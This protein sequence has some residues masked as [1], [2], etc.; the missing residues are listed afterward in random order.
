M[1][2]T[3][4]I[5]YVGRQAVKVLGQLRKASG[6]SGLGRVGGIRKE[7]GVCGKAV[8][9]SLSEG[10]I[11]FCQGNPCLSL[12]SAPLAVFVRGEASSKA[13]HL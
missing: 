10:A 9:P 5:A 1:C 3:G 13:C 6:S 11:H 7:E 12:L 2:V 4:R 8:R